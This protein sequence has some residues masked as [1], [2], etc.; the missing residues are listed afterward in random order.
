MSEATTVGFAGIGRMGLPMAR[1]ILRAGFPLIAWNRTA[2]RCLPLVEE[3]ATA[4]G[5]AVELAAADV[6]VTTLTD[7]VAARAVLV[8]SGL[9]DALRPGA[10]VLEMSTIGP[11]AARDLAARADRRRVALLDAPVS[12]SV[13]VAEAG[14]SSRWSEATRTRTSERVR[15]S[16]R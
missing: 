5:A 16:T 13:A 7:A 12:G 15:C 3:G 6:V 8:D 10:I 11:R 9:L 1:N 4:A 14:S 2:E